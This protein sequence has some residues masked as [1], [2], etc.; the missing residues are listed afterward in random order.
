MI[1]AAI[2]EDNSDAQERL[3]RYLDRYQNEKSQRVIVSCFSDAIDFIS[4]Y[5][6]KYDVVFMD[7]EMPHINGMDAAVRLR[8]LDTNI[9]LVF[10]TNM[11]QYAVR[12]YE[13]DAMGYMLKP[14]DYFAFRLQ[15]DK[16][17]SRITLKADV[18]IYIKT[19]EYMKRVFL[20]DLMYVDV[21]GHY[22]TYHTDSGDYREFGQLN[23]LEGKLLSNY[24]FR[25]NK[26]CIVNLK[27]VTKMEDDAI[28]VGDNKIQISRRR[29]KDFLIALNGFFNG[30]LK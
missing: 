11:A 13:V 14:V 26:Y 12:G 8:R 29:K 23:K 30:G 28:L 7:I 2:V 22:L 5:E 17:V 9:C 10:I 16:V 3:V 6:P 20:R 27:Y 25:C 24:F 1:H 21:S 4:D 15:M 19:S 18:E